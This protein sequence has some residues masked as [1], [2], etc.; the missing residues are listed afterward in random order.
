MN[1]SAERRLHAL[2]DDVARLASS[3]GVEQDRELVAADPRD[4]VAGTQA[5]PSGAPPAQPAARSPTAWLRLSLTSLKRSMSRNRT[6]QPTRGSRVARWSTWS[7]RSMNRARLG[8]AGQA[9]VQRVVLELQLGGAAVGD[10]G[11]R[12][13]H[14]RRLAVLTRG[15]PGR[16]SAPSASLR[17]RGASGARTRRC[18]VCP[19]R[20]ASIAARRRGRSSSCTRSNQAAGSSSSASLRPGRASPASAARSR[21]G[22]PCRSQSQIPSLAARTASA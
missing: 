13:G 2:G 21:S 10:V 22:R 3:D 7:R 16:G 12:A 19:A 9:V 1:G 17:P 20:C 11:Q 4:R 6:A 14:P 15:W 18:G 5:R 8:E